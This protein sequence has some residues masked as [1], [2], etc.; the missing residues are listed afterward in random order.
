MSYLNWNLGI[1]EMLYRPKIFLSQFKIQFEKFLGKDTVSL[2]G[3]QGT[4]TTGENK[5]MKVP[6]EKACFGE[7]NKVINRN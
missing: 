5:I 1:I 3:F 6:V 2:A 4:R 7:V